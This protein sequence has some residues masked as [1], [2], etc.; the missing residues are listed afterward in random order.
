MN[1]DQLIEKLEEIK[2]SDSDV[3][4]NG[5][6]SLDGTGWC[7]TDIVNDETTRIMRKWSKKQLE[8]ALYEY[9]TTRR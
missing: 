6:G 9:T 1:R 3:W 2:S 7:A 4:E 5:F 8:T